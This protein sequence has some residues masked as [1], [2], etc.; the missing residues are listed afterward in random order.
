MAKVVAY[1][2]D[3]D[4]LDNESWDDFHTRTQGVM[5][6]LL[7]RSDAL[8]DDVVVKGV[9]SFPVADGSAFYMVSKEK[10]LH[11]IHIPYMDAWEA[12]EIT[13]RGLNVSDVKA[14]LKRSKSMPRLK[15]LI[16]IPSVEEAKD[17]LAN[18]KAGATADLKDKVKDKAVLDVENRFNNA[19]D[20]AQAAFW[21]V[22]TGSFPEIK[23]GDLSADVAFKFHNVINK[24]A[25]TWLIDNCPDEM[26]ASELVPSEYLPKQ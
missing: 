7:A 3:F 19:M 9:I 26:E 10:P 2:G 13:I 12:D 11:L 6:G 15:P 20:D 14:M 17:T 4:K 8:P 5:D 21:G 23:S 16:H 1:A 25:A 18:A 22:I 24:T